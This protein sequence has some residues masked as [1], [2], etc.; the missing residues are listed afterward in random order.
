M[1][2]KRTPKRKDKD[3]EKVKDTSKEEKI[4]ISKNVRKTL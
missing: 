3:V 2:A 4:T 1:Q